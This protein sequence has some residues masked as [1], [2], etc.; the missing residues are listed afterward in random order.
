LGIE[1]QAGL[2][3]ES[4]NEF[5]A[6]LDA[7]EQPLGGCGELIHRYLTCSEASPRRPRTANPGEN[8]I[9]YLRIGEGR[10]YLA[11][12]IDLATRMVVGWQ[13]AAH[14]RTAW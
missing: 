5:G 13:L 9:T 8:L 1:G 11:T 14:M 2:S 10:L 12:V 4:V 7:L 6:V 3:A